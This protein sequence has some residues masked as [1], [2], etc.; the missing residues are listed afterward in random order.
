MKKLI[1]A[2]VAALL[3][4]ASVAGSTAGLCGQLTAEQD[5]V[6]CRVSDI[7]GLGST[8]LIRVHARTGDD[9]ARVAR[10]KAATRQAIDAFLAEGGVF[11]KMRTTRPDGVEV[12]RTCS[13]VKGRKSEHCGEWSP[14]KG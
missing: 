9:E 4:T 11:I 7:D 5:G 14:V 1:T 8:L 12:E 10:A 2:F 6:K 3:S 13:K